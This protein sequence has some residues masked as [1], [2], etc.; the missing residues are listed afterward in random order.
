LKIGRAEIPLPLFLAPMAGITD[1]PFRALCRFHG[2]PV[3]FSEMISSAGICQ[4]GKRTMAYLDMA[5][6]AGPTFMQIFGTDPVKMARAAELCAGVPG[7]V[8]VD[9]NMGCPVRKVVRSGA[10]AALMGRPHL[11]A[12]IVEAVKKA[13]PLPVTVK[14]RSGL[15]SVS[16]TAVEFAGAME[17]AGA[18]AV[19]VHPRTAAQGY[20]GRADWSVISAVKR[21]VKIPV[22]GNGDVRGA[23]DAARMIEET[24]C[25]GVMVGRGALGNPWVFESISKWMS[26]GIPREIRPEPREL[27]S[28][29][30][31]HYDMMVE[32]RRSEE[33]A[34]KVMRKHLAYY[35]KG[36]PGAAGA[37]QLIMK[38]SKRMEVERLLMNCAGG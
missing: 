2:M 16:V 6:D 30:M 15:T 4:G 29:A 28:T 36:L 38:A 1:P 31:R 24:G 12:R 26:G 3:A 18:D 34:I 19:T 17:D 32:Y 22:I 13:C 14:F 5:M 7:A 10:G 8:G 37:R 9:V 35:T 27:V 20:A 21:T 25:D 33:R 23:F 11:A